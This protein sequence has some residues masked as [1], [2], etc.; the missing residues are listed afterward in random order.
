MSCSV[1]AVIAGAVRVPVSVNGVTIPHDLI[2]REAQNH[3]A[4]APVGAWR[5]AARALAV[6]E[7]LVQ[8][9][10]RLERSPTP[11][12]DAEGRRETDEEALIRCLI[13]AQV[14]VPSADTDSCQRYYERNRARFRSADIYE[15][16]H[17]LVAAR[18]DDPAAFAATR[19]RALALLAQVQG[20]PHCFPELAKARS[21][22]PSAASG[23]NLGQLTAGDTTPEFEEALLALKP[24]ATTSAPIET[25]Y[26]FHIIRLDRHIPGRELPFELVHQRI[27]DYLVERSRRLAIAQYV[28]RLASNAQISG[29]DLATPASLRVN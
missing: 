27:A 11:L 5:E 10:R 26:G 25:R 19:E 23:G 9:A 21:D 18:S 15:A 3:P 16:S 4:S 24:G 2:A 20:D 1:R 29:V 22:C 6:R 7:L 13:D 14:T 8:E 12:I 28:A 17:I